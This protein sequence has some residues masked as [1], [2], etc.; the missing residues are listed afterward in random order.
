MVGG[1]PKFTGHIGYIELTAITQSI[2]N[3]VLGTVL[4][5][6]VE[7]N[8]RVACGFENKQTLEVHPLRE[9]HNKV[10]TYPAVEFLRG[11]SPNGE[12]YFLDQILGWS[13]DEWDFQHNFIQW[14]F[15]TTEPS[16]FNPDA[17][18]LTPDEITIIKADP[19]IQG[20]LGV[21]FHRW[22]RFCGLSYTDDMGLEIGTTEF[23]EGNPKVFW[24][25]NHNFLRITRVLQSLTLLGRRDRAEE[26][27][28]F[29]TRNR[30]YFTD[31]TFGYWTA[32]MGGQNDN[33]V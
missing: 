21:I 19:N 3:D 9:D 29:L 6:A 5:G 22:L 31:N 20:V 1:T 15:P 18:V 27:F 32:A 11:D 17:P 7:H 2:T 10:S 16:N 26:L 4:C 25:F 8:H 24:K 23:P 12:G 30:G 13:N 28:R 33:A 14:V